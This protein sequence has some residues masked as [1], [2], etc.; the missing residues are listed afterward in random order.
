MKRKGAT[1]EKD[2]AVLVFLAKI[3]IQELAIK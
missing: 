3:M 2:S 1:F